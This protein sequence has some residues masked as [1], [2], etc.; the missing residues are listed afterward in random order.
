MDIYKKNRRSSILPGDELYILFLAGLL[1]V[2]AI[3][4]LS[5][6]MIGE[7]ESP[8]TVVSKPPCTEAFREDFRETTLLVKG[9]E[10]KG[11]LKVLD[12]TRPYYVAF[13]YQLPDEVTDTRIEQLTDADS[14]G[15]TYTLSNTLYA[16]LI[17]GKVE[18]PEC[19]ERVLVS[20][21]MATLP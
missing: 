2:C 5:T 18:W 12:N 21:F 6:L 19:D 17:S 13:N 11:K 20:D 16:F 8:Q 3:G 4:L 7:D 1:I 10:L 15:V 14:W 9:R